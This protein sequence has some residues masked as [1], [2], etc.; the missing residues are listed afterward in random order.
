MRRR[1]HACVMRRRIRVGDK[2]C[3]H[4]PNLLLMESMRPL[5]HTTNRQVYG[6]LDFFLV[7]DAKF[8]ALRLFERDRDVMIF[9]FDVSG[10]LNLIGAALLN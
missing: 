10:F 8:L 9:Q 7:R 3:R 2:I 5:L 1:I 6:V 4:V